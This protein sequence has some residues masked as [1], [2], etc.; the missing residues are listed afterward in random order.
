MGF[1]SKPTLTILMSTY[2]GQ[3]YISEQLNSIISQS[4]ESWILL[5]RDDG[6]NDETR[7]IIS[8]YAKRDE[9]IIIVDDDLGNLGSAGS[10]LK[11]LKL[12]DTAY[13][14]FSDQDDIWLPD[15]VS[16]TLNRI[17]SDDIPQLVFTDL[18]VVDKNL[19]VLSDSFMKLSRFDT[20][21]GVTFSRLIIQ[22]IVVGC[23]MA[24]NRRL[25]ERSGL[26]NDELI[27]SVVMHDWWLALTACVHGELIYVSDKTILY[28][29]HGNNHIGVKKLDLKRY[30]KLLLNEKPWLKARDYLDMVTKQAQAFRTQNESSFTPRQ[31]AQIN[32]LISTRE[33]GPI[34][35]LLKCFINNV[36]M[37]KF[38]RNFALLVSFIGADT[39]KKWK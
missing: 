6:S 12:V 10:F 39:R 4:Y 15:K 17:T 16:V 22:N 32:L 38:D 35:T 36:S 27:E 24:G 31:K 2:N 11:L 25:I 20:Q 13:F 9:R 14:M 28:R 23:T 18:H 29:Q 8:E 1:C 5:V 21:A 37:H 3:K 26:L 19:N 33:H 34:Q 7:K 30:I